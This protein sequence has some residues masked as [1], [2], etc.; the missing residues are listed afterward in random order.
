[1]EMTQL[2]PTSDTLAAAPARSGRAMTG[3][4]ISKGFLTALALLGFV[5]LAVAATAPVADPVDW[6]AASSGA[7]HQG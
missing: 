5:V 7:P 2:T 1:M 3:K 4:G 6:S